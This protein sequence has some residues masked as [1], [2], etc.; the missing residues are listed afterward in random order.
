[1]FVPKYGET[2]WFVADW[3]K[4]DFDVNTERRIDR[5]RIR[6]RRV[7]RDPGDYYEKEIMN[8]KGGEGCLPIN[9]S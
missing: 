2:Y 3:N 4:I 1:M 6:Q 5:I 8:T 7:Y 9:A